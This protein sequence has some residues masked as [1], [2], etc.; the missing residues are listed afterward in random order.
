MFLYYI[1]F[2]IIFL[3]DKLLDS[4]KEDNGRCSKDQASEFVPSKF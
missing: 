2:A 3:L 4:I 1:E